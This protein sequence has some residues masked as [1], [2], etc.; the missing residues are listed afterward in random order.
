M[1]LIGPLA[2]IVV[3][4]TLILPRVVVA[5]TAPSIPP[6]ITTADKVETR[7]GTLEFKD[8]APNRA[9]AE[10]VFDNLDFTYA[11]RAFMDNMR[12]VSIHALRK[13]L[14]DIGV[15]DNE[16]I[17]FSE[18]MDAKSLFLTANADT[19]YVIGTLDL[20]KGPMVVETPPKFLGTVQDAWFRW[21]IDLGLPGPDR[22]EGGKYLIVP[23][24]Y[25]GELPDGGF[26]VARARTNTIAW[27]G[28]SFLENHSDPKPVAETIKKFT[29]VYPYER[30]GVGTT[31]AEFLAGKAKLGRITPPPP[32]V[33]HEGSGKV[34]NTIPPNDWSFYEMLN[35]VVQR[36][37]ATSLDPELMGPIAAIG[38]VKGKPFAPD[39]RMKKI[40]TEALALANATS[41]SLFMAP[42]DP[43]WFYYPNSSWFNYLFVTGYEFETPI[44]EIT[45]EGVKPFPPTGYRTMDARTNFFYGVTGITPAMAMRLPGIGSQYLFA[46]TD[47]EKNYFDGAK[48]YKVTLPKGIPEENFWSFTIYDNQTRSMLDTPQR[49]PRAGSQS[50]PSPA[51]EPDADG[52]TTIYF[53]PTQ[54]AGIKR[55]NWIQTDPKKGWFTILRLYSPLEPF[56]TKAW[57]PSEI[58][59]VR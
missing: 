57:R 48:T 56:F 20:S 39:A 41:R 46:V 52:S 8:G 37:P 58:A 10:K 18:L 36:E 51:A 28:R 53:G 25:S 34:F 54:P 49:Y 55:G 2:A 23:P 7:V 42:R 14:Q 59:L 24:D 19:I 4:A 15:K 16:V 6:S 50:Y 47:A 11:Y 9:T 21:V 30:G 44:P 33:I 35:E 31:V 22:G 43:S 32:T 3:C 17:V 29:K 26:F 40:M 12:G 5:Q 38:I 13:G 27:F 1:K 45:R